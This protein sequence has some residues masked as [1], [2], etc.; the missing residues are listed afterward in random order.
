MGGGNLMLDNASNFSNAEYFNGSATATGSVVT[1]PANRY[2]S[3]DIQLSVAQSGAGTATASVQYNTSGGT[4]S[5][6]DNS[7]VARIQAVGLLGVSSANADTVTL[8]GYTGSGGATLDFTLSG[9]G[10][11]VIN[12]VLQ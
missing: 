5:P 1:L 6:A 12:G 7:I 10:S 11:C 3:C 8:A 9:T 2:F 4:F